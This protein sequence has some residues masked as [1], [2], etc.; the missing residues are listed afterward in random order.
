MLDVFHGQG[1]CLGTRVVFHCSDGSVDRREGLEEGYGEECAWGLGE[2]V[3]LFCDLCIVAGDGGFVAS[4]WI[5][6]GGS[7]TTFVE[8]N[9]SCCRA[10][11]EENIQP[12]TEIGRCSVYSA[13]Q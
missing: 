7:Y 8:S 4:S 13:I 3:G 9:E 2:A 5:W 11:L 6:W 1:F 12:L 10:R